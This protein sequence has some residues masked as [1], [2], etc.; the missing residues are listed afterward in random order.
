[1]P[2][3]LYLCCHQH[4]TDAPSLL[5]I[6]YSN[7]MLYLMSTDVLDL[8]QNIHLDYEYFF[9]RATIF[10]Y[11][12]Q[13]STSKMKHTPT[14]VHKFTRHPSALCINLLSSA[15]SIPIYQKQIYYANP[16]ITT[17]I[18]N[19]LKIIL[20]KGIL[21]FTDSVSQA[22]DVHTSKY[23]YMSKASTI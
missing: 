9:P 6:T 10:S 13:A 20:Q 3:S 15:S 14:E 21:S 11:I 17:L 22:S 7:C 2:A 5:M 23:N 19:I 16:I 4:T 12:F 1:M 8:K 18:I